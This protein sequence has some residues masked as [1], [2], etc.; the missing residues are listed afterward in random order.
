MIEIKKKKV[1]FFQVK[2]MWLKLDS[3]TAFG[4]NVEKDLDFVFIL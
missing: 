1:W 3:S 2:K 4:F